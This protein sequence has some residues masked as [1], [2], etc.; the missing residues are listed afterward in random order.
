MEL[1]TDG[2]EVGTRG[3][4]V[5]VL[6]VLVSDDRSPVIFRFALFGLGLPFVSCQERCTFAHTER[7]RTCIGTQKAINHYQATWCH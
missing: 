2:P 1:L 7:K 6:V 4:L 5:S 3:E